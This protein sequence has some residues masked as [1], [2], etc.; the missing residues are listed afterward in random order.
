[1]T[2]G[3]AGSHGDGA[4]AAIIVDHDHGRV[5]GV[6]RIECFDPEFTRS[7]SHQG[8]VA[9]NWVMQVSCQP[10]GEAW[11]SAGSVTRSDCSRSK[12]DHRC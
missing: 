2:G 12:S 3:Q 7:T 9:V 11:A 6:L 8:N 4:V 5:A 10:S 1:M